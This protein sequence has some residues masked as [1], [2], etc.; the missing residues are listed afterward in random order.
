MIG[1]LIYRYKAFDVEVRMIYGAPS[2]VWLSEWPKCSSV[3]YS[4][5]RAD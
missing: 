4:I 3:K 1:V 5:L 2:S